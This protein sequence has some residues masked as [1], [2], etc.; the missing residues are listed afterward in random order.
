MGLKEKKMQK[1]I[2]ELI[3]QTKSFRQGQIQLPDGYEPTDAVEHHDA[4]TSVRETVH[5]GKSIEVYTT[6]RILVDGEPIRE[7]V[8][9]LEDGTVHYHG[10]PNYSFPSVVELARRIVERSLI[11][12]P[13]DKLNPS[14]SGTRGS[15][16][17]K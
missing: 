11:E 16:E 17:D 9:A 4:T 12:R 14:G 15:E 13:R 2:A 1:P 3:R 5:C 8:V 7:H 6:Y 10:L